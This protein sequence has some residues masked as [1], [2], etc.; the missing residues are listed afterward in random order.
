MKGLCR[1]YSRAAHHLEPSWCLSCLLLFFSELSRAPNNLL[2][3][4]LTGL[5]LAFSVQRQAAQAPI[6]N[7]HELNPYVASAVEDWRRRHS[8][9]AAL[10]RQQAPKPVSATGSMAA[11][12]GTS[13][14]GMSGVNAHMLLSAVAAAGD[15]AAAAGESLPWQRQRHWPATAPHPLVQLVSSAGSAALFSCRF[16]TASSAFLRDHCISGRLLV[17]ATAFFELLLAAGSSAA[18]DSSKQ[19]LQPSL[20]GVA[21]MAPKVLSQDAAGGSGAGQVS[22]Q[23]NDGAAE[24]LSVDGT[25]HVRGAFCTAAALPVP[26]QAAGSG[27]ISAR[28]LLPNSQLGDAY[29]R[30]YNFAAISSAA[31]C[32]SGSGWHA[33]P[34][35][36]DA[37]LHLGAVKVAQLGDSASRVP[38][39]VAAVASPAASAASMQQWSASELPVV[40]ADRSALCTIRAQLASACFTACGL[41]SKPLPSKPAGAAAADAAAEAKAFEQ[42]N[43]TYS[44]QWQAAAGSAVAECDSS[45][46]PL[47]RGGSLHLLADAVATRGGMPA[48]LASAR[49]LAVAAARH[50]TGNPVAVAAGSI[51]MLQ[52]ILAAGGTAPVHAL[53]ISASPSPAVAEGCPASAALAAVLKVAAVENPSRQ[54]SSLAVD[55][56]QRLPSGSLPTATADQHGALLSAGAISHPNLLRQAM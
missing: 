10:P 13:S 54:W 28:Q 33:Q 30:H 31:A 16:S 38:V 44:I 15:S 36:A 40:A 35:A 12:A 20:V 52:R 55:A 49:L 53:S 41:H 3:P 14:F 29:P 21:I 7:L 6:V 39:A 11:V 4:G 19:Q 22:L 8:L 37:G 47:A 43:F 18:E 5:L 9:L 2:F 27:T 32:G 46:V 26:L 51:E 23:L 45:L 17:P 1:M 48:A 25:S 50:G 24:V 56:Q 34:A 42:R